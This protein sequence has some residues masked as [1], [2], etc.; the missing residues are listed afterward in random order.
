[1]QEIQE[2]FFSDVTPAY[3]PGHFAVYWLGTFVYLEG[4]WN[5]TRR[6]KERELET[7]MTDEGHSMLLSGN[8]VTPA[9]MFPVFFFSLL[10]YALKFLYGNALIYLGYWS[11][12]GIFLINIP[13]T[14]VDHYYLYTLRDQSE[15]W[16][17]YPGSTAESQ[18]AWE[19]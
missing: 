6:T 11:L 4:I 5:L 1:M 15:Y 14:F 8:W 7:I 19:K 10:A 17:D 12:I 13:A 16:V 2:A 18:A 3:N 9:T